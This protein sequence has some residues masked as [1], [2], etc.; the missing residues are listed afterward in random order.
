MGFFNS[1]LA[2]DSSS[3]FHP[4][5]KLGNFRLIKR[6]VLV[7]SE[8]LLDMSADVAR[9][10]TA[11]HD[12]APKR[13]E[14]PLPTR[15]LG[16]RSGTMLTEEE[17]TAWTQHAACFRKRAL[18]IRHGAKRKS[19]YYA[20]KAGILEFEIFAF[21]GLDGDIETYRALRARGDCPQLR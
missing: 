10:M 3:P 17:Q 13:I 2:R 16:I 6:V 9:D 5:Q 14:A 7:Y 4:A 11:A 1:P 19:A 21:S 12:A 20:V 8:V 18:G 15:N